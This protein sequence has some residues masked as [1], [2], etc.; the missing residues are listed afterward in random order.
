MGPDLRVGKSRVGGEGVLV[1]PIVPIINGQHNI[2]RAAIGEP[3]VYRAA[4]VQA[5]GPHVYPL[6]HV[7]DVGDDDEH[8]DE[9]DG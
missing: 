4:M 8:D 1:Q 6:A 5:S 9:S 2:R 7:G 3:A